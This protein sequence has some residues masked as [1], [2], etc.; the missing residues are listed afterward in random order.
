MTRRSKAIFILPALCVVLLGYYALAFG[1]LAVNATESLQGNAFAM[2]TWPKLIKPGRIV[3]VKMPDVLRPAFDGGE[4][5]LTKRVVGVA[6]DPVT[7][8]GTRLC[9]NTSCV[10][11]HIKTGKLVSPLWGA[12]RVPENEIAIFGDSPDSLDSRYEVIGGIS[13]DDVVAAGFAIPFPH[14]TRLKEWLQ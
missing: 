13:R 8:D 10:E 2:V 12:D 1:R 9:I 3:A 14:W 4:L 11:G 7:R 6:G 5:Y